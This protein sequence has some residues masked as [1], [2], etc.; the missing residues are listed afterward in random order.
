MARSE[1][2]C[3]LLSFVF[4][5]KL[6]SGVEP[7]KGRARGEHGRPPGPLVGAAATLLWLLSLL[8]ARRRTERCRCI[9]RSYCLPLIANLLRSTSAGRLVI[10]LFDDIAPV[11]AMAFRNR[12][13]GALAWAAAQQAL[14]Q[15]TTSLSLPVLSVALLLK[16]VQQ[17]LL[18]L[19]LVLPVAPP[20]TVLHIWWL[21]RAPAT[22]SRAPLSTRL[23]GT[24]APLEG[25]R[26]GGTRWVGGG[27]ACCAL[28]LVQLR[29][30]LHPAA[31]TC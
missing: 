11:A 30:P 20:L 19:L 26:P 23:F 24:W 28:S 25:R 14:R 4:G 12:C 31:S 13:S 7:V 21:Q 27:G 17:L 3:W 8:D 9:S 5:A 16:P 18:I 2:S 1:V 10:E 22:L 6:F 29:P 15:V